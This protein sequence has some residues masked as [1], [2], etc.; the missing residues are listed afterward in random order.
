MKLFYMLLSGALAFLAACCAVQARPFPDEK[1]WIKH[2]DEI[3]D[4]AT[5]T[6]EGITLTF[7]GTIECDTTKIMEITG[8]TVIRSHESLDTAGIALLV[9]P[10][11]ELTIR[12]PTIKMKKG[13]ASAYQGSMPDQQPILRVVGSVY[14]QVTSWVKEHLEGVPV[15][16]HGIG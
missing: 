12:A 8:N 15:D 11:A 1:T 6:A 4:E 16:D 9:H 10:G 7:L 3:P 5:L 2:C 14:F 13:E